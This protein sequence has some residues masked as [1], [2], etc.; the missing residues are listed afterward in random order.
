[1]KGCIGMPQPASKRVYGFRFQVPGLWFMVTGLEF[2]IWSLEFE[3][4]RL[5]SAVC[6]LPSA[7]SRLTFAF[8]P[9]SPSSTGSVKTAMPIKWRAQQLRLR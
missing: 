4:F 1:M 2:D 6:R 3:I 5:P 7:V 8:C 9:T